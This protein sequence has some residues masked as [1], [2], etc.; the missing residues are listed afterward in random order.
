[1]RGWP[2]DSTK[3]EKLVKEGSV[4]LVIKRVMDVESGEG[5]RVHTQCN[6]RPPALA[7]LHPAPIPRRSIARGSGIYS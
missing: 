2:W 1:M 7:G 3:E 5:E 4:S 6:Q